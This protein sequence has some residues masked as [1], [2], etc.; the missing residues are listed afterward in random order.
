M[1]FPVDQRAAR[2][3]FGDL[4]VETD[5]IENF[6]LTDPDFIQMGFS[7][8]CTRE[9]AEMIP[10]IRELLTGLSGLHWK[11]VS[12]IIEAVIGQRLTHGT[13]EYAGSWKAQ[14]R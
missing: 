8:R 9:T 3:L 10:V 14:E 6:M 12:I 4:T 11:Y 13:L 2:M 5:F 7:L 1:R